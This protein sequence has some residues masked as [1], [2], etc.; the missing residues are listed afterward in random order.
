[1]QKGEYQ[2]VDQLHTVV[3]D[4]EKGMALRQAN[5]MKA[6]DTRAQR[7]KQEWKVNSNLLEKTLQVMSMCGAELNQHRK[8]AITTVR[9]VAESGGNS[10]QDVS[11][12]AAESITASALNCDQYK[13][14]A[15]EDLENMAQVVQDSAREVSASGQ[16][17]QKE[18]AALLQSHE[19]FITDQ[20]K[21]Y[22]AV[23]AQQERYRE[24]ARPE[25]SKETSVMKS[26]KTKDVTKRSTRREAPKHRAVS[27]SNISGLEAIEETPMR[28]E[29]SEMDEPAR[30]MRRPRSK[31]KGH[32]SATTPPQQRKQDRKLKV[33][34]HHG[35]EIG[36]MDSV[37]RL[38]GAYYGNKDEDFSVW[39]ARAESYGNA[40][41]SSEKHMHA[42][43]ELLLRGQAGRTYH[44]TRAEWPEDVTPPI[45]GVVERMQRYF[46]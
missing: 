40:H 8:D 16:E 4:Y 17:T 19:G 20:R 5:T 21:H 43:L 13:Q 42:I 18:M 15:R 35:Q 11:Q 6:A 7:N 1:M 32:R 38:V 14:Q 9:K 3:K 10:I 24:L 41:R 23:L 34:P 25:E 2:V 22:D 12:K 31:S 36:S 44:H 29:A 39:W 45:Y 26:G 27:S 30:A 28:S 46:R 33:W 37:K